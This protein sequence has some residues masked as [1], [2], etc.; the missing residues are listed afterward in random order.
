M[1]HRR[2]RY[3]PDWLGGLSVEEEACR[4]EAVAL[5]RARYL[6]LRTRLWRAV[7]EAGDVRLAAV[8]ALRSYGLSYSEACAV[9]GVPLR[10]AKRLVAGFKARLSGTDACRCTHR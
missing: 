8:L 2:I 6:A 4:R 3:D 9:C 5:E 10:T 1:R 7:V